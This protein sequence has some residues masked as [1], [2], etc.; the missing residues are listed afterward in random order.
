MFF[1]TIVTCKDQRICYT[2]IIKLTIGDEMKNPLVIAMAVV[3]AAVLLLL[4]VFV[5]VD[6]V[7]AVKALA[8]LVAAIQ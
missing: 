8:A 5:V 7:P 2:V 3:A 4:A 1:V 6:G